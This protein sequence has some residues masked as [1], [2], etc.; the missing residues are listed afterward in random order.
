MTRN[1]AMASP[2]VTSGAN[3]PGR[4]RTAREIATT[5]RRL[6]RVMMARRV[7]FRVSEQVEGGVVEE[8]S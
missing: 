7:R 1:E 2:R 8:A 6:R 3:D 5:E 4:R